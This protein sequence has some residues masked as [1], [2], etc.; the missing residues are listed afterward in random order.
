M[1]ALVLDPDAKTPRGTIVYPGPFGGGGSASSA[2]MYPDPAVPP[3]AS[4]APAARAQRLAEAAADAQA[5]MSC[6]DGWA[7]NE[8]WRRYRLIHDGGR[9]PQELLD[10]GM[11]LSRVALDLAHESRDGG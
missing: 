4:N 9:D 1:M 5:A 7:L 6:G 2:P 10:E 8:A 11:Q 3:T